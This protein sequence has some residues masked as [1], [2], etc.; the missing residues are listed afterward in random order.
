MFLVLLVIAFSA[1]STSAHRAFSFWDNFVSFYGCDSTGADNSGYQMMCY[2]NCYENPYFDWDAEDAC[3]DYC[4]GRG[5]VLFESSID[6]W[7]E[8]DCRPF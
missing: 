2:E 7:T 1:R 8:C 3:A 5:E 6:C 4:G